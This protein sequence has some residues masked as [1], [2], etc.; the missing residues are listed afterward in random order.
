[1]E[2]ST[3]AREVLEV[4]Y[5]R[6]DP[7]GRL[8]TPQQ[9][10]ARVARAVAEGERSFGNASA[11]R[12]WQDRF[13]AALSQ[14]L[15]LPNSPTLMN[16]GTSLAQLSACF[17]LPVEDSLE[18]I[19][20][21]LR[22]MALIQQSGGGTGFSFSRLRPRGDVVAS[23]DGVASGP[24]SFM[25]IFD[26]A[27]DNIRQGGRRRGANMG[28]LRVDHP[29]IEEFIGAKRDGTSFSNFNVSVAATDAFM[30]AALAGESF[31]L[32]SPRTRELLRTVDASALLREIADA[33]WHTGDPG[34]VFIDAV[35]RANPTP[36]LGEIEATNPCGEVPLLPYEACNLA[37]ITL[38]RFVR[39]G[40][41]DW[42]ALA[43]V[44]ALGMHFLDDVI[45]VSRWPDP[46]IAEMVRTNRKVGLG[47]MGF[48]DLL[49]RLGI[50]YGSLECL[51]LAERLMG[52]I[53]D[54]ARRA[55]EELARKRGPFPSYPRSRHAGAPPLRN[56]T[57]TSIAPTGTIGILADTS[58]SIEPLFGLAYRR[59]NVLEGRRLV[60]LNPLFVDYAKRNGFYSE[61]LVSELAAHGSLAAVPGVP[62][63]ARQLFRTALE[64]D[65]EEHLAV[66]VAFQKHVDNAVS[67]TINLPNSATPDDVL[68]IY[69]RAWELGLKG[70]TI[71]R[72][73]SKAQQVLHLG[74]SDD[75]LLRE[76][77]SRCDPEGCRL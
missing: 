3:N 17:V 10:F 30:Q 36:E 65:P 69:R 26:C 5:A 39:D 61:R 15:L 57:R 19:F 6:R 46:R 70:I 52:F 75:P 42:S 63:S 45:E 47:V 68:R 40:A 8:E 27:T 33:A 4:R 7:S 72:Y 20:D 21:S 25:R 29:D 34:L 32:V 37:S 76:H 22:L 43:D 59:E 38:P 64:L 35:A 66:Q 58:P 77:G 13:E 73:G 50:P 62:E 9:V 11:V 1:M 67:K 23:T 48:A 53:D 44:V 31:A 55:S 12:R 2:L 18:G 49:I 41:L 16:A 54:H 28:I 71:Y 60:E 24:V 74:A 56:A 51:E 14:R